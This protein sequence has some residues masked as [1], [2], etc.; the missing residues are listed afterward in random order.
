MSSIYF[1]WK[2]VLSS[3]RAMRLNI[4][5]ALQKTCSS[6]D[7]WFFFTKQRFSI[8]LPNYLWKMKSLIKKHIIDKLLVPMTLVTVY[9]I[10][11]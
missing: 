3:A 4:T 7:N 1:M 10:I 9:V 6:S 5:R 2:Y 11:K 8:N